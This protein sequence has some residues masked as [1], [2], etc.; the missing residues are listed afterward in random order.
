MRF[1]RI[2]T[3]ASV[4]VISALALTG[5]GGGSSAG[6]GDADSSAV[7]TAD[8]V[9]PQNPLVPTNTSE[10]G[11]GVVVENIFNG[12]ISYDE[13]G[14]PQNDLAESIDSDD[15]QNWTIKIKKDKKFT[16]GEPVT[17]QSFVDSW[18][19]G[20]AAKN[21]QAAS[22]FFSPIEG[23]DAVSGEGSTE[24]KMSGLQV[25][26]DNTFTVKLNS[27]QSDFDLRLGYAAY[28]PM[29][30]SA[31]KDMKAFGENPV[32]YGP[33]K[34]AKEG[35]WQHNTQIDL[36]K[37]DDYDGPEKPKNGGITFKLYQN[38]DTAYQDLL[39]NNLDVLQ[40][41]PTSALGNYKD[42]LGDRSLDKPYAGNQTIA[43]PYYLKNWSGEAG[44]LRRQALSMAIDRDEI[45]KVILNNTRKPATDMTAP[46]LEGY[47][48]K[49]ENSDNTKFD[50]DKAKELWDKAEKMQPYDTSE[51]F[52]IAYNADAGGHKKWVDAVANQ[53]KNNLGIDAEGKSYS[54][55]KEV[56]TDATSGKLTGAVRSGWLGDYPSLYN[57]ME[58]TYTKG[59]NSNDSKYDNPEFEKKLNEGLAATDKDAANKA[60][61]EADSMLLE[62][63]PAIPLWYSQA[64][65]G[66]SESV[67][68]VKAS[69]NGTPMYYNVEKSS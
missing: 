2:S 41:I 64:N 65:V 46:V 3:F 34:M 44:K 24:D 4:A 7:I 19:Y 33:Y 6:S 47:K 32:G 43:I 37:N 13:D 14:K 35:A 58:P 27:P 29:P 36:V 49:I 48:D 38:P 9:E 22:T 21:A 18:N 50:K 10:N 45:T 11:G 25:K 15:N 52:T 53:I 54:T 12:L 1:S 62:D 66:W 61:R 39:A 23:Y 40:Q 42:D 30:E 69:W 55:F 31:F 59:A 20:A 8:S 56:R 67:S 5:C 63:L 16:N 57:F 26:D 60:F 68:G 28:V 51:K 17:A